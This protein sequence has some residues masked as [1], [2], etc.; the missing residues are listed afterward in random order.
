MAAL[1]DVLNFT[2]YVVGIFIGWICYN[3]VV[4][5]LNHAYR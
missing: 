4:L 2:Y 3:V 1:S 5:H